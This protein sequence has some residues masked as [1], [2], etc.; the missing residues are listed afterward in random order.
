[1][2]EQSTSIYYLPSLGVSKQCLRNQICI[3]QST[4]QANIEEAENNRVCY[5]RFQESWLFLLFTVMDST[6]FFFF[7]TW[8]Q[9]K[10][11]HQCHVNTWWSCISKYEI[12]I[13][14]ALHPQNAKLEVLTKIDPLAS[15][16][17][18]IIPWS[19]PVKIIQ[20][21]VQYNM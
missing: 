16:H 17:A 8:K 11:K 12:Q 18:I 9:T 5:I 19:S 13:Y 7:S 4:I 2:K 21:V 15:T 14:Q 20:G 3:S 6:S 10:D 1:M